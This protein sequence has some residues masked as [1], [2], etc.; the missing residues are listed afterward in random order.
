MVLNQDER[1]AL[2]ALVKKRGIGGLGRHIFLCMG[3]KCC[4][5]AQGLASWTHLK[6]KI[7]ELNLHAQVYRTKVGCLRICAS[8][9]IGVVYPEGTWYMHMTPDN[10]D[11]IVTEHLIG[12]EPVND[13]IFARNPLP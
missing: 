10:I 1:A 9:P 7:H 2:E 3:P 4:S 12:G 13:L 6:A 11:R 5:E 8:G